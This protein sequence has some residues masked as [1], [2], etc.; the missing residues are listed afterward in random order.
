MKNGGKKIEAFDT[1]L[2]EQYKYEF[3]ISKF[4]WILLMGIGML[5]LLI[6]FKA[7]WEES[8]LYI[9]FLL[10]EMGTFWYIRSYLIVT[11]GGKQVS[12]YQKLKWTPVSRK[13]IRLS[14]VKYLSTFCLKFFVASMLMQQMTSFVGGSFGIGSLLYPIIFWLLIWLIGIGYIYSL[15]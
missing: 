6:P 11:D 12:I 15:K 4:L 8:I 10:V 9:V 2:R 5:M 7:I 3:L 14:R 1:A 13:E